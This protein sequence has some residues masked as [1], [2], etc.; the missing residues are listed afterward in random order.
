MKQF[1]VVATATLLSLVSSGALASAIETSGVNSVQDIYV[2][3][4]GSKPVITVRNVA[5]NKQLDHID[6]EPQSNTFS[7]KLKGGVEC[8]VVFKNTVSVK[9][10]YMFREG[11]LGVGTL[12]T[13]YWDVQA[14]TNSNINKSDHLVTKTVN[15]PIAAFNGTAHALDLE[16][17]ILEK[18]DQHAQ[19]GGNKVSYLRQ[20]HNFDVQIPIRFAADCPTYSRHKLFK[21]QTVIEA[22]GSYI[23]AKRMTTIRIAYKGDPNL[24]GTVSLAARNP[25]AQQGGYNAGTQNFID[26]NSGKFLIGPVKLKGKCALEGDFKIEI[27]GAGDGDLKIRIND[28]GGT[29]HDS[30]TVSFSQGKAVYSFKKKVGQYSENQLNKTYG[31]KYQ[32]Y[33][34]A[35]TKN[36]AFFPSHYTPVSGAFLNWDHTCIRPVV[37]NP[38]IRGGGHN[39]KVYAPAKPKPPRAKI[40]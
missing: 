39:D 38:A 32:V 10:G 28:D 29:I 14:G 16:N 15:V 8:G 23:V 27:K 18:A 13:A 2:G 36:E 34:K 31:H 7:M 17:F 37:V 24:T 33:V 26:I 20:D 22:G 19:G 30:P 25:S 4:V 21:K 5:G 11:R 9:E 35:K 3:N 1:T 6:L 12:Q 40:N